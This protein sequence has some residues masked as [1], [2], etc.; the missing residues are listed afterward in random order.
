MASVLDQLREVTVVV[1][2]TGDVE[3]VKRYKPVDCTT[4]PSLVL[5]ALKD[6]ASEE[7]VAKE[8]EVGR[9]SGL[10]AEALT[11]ILTV[12]VPEPRH[13]ECGCEQV[14]PRQRPARDPAPLDVLPATC[15]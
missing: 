11:A 4:N 12:A 15:L 5:N 3:A 9:K 7:L 1:A 10:S 8:I 6:Q 14:P 2:D 13:P